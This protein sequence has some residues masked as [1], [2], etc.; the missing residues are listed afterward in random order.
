VR[1]SR[2]VS[3]DEMAASYL[4][5]VGDVRRGFNHLAADVTLDMLGQCDRLVVLDVGAGEG[6]I[7]RRLADLGAHVVAV[8]PTRDLLNAAVTIERDAPR[9]I[10]YYADYVEDLRSVASESVDAAVAVLVLH[11][12]VDLDIALMEL[13]RVLRPRGRLVL[14]IPHP[15]SDHPGAAWQAVEQGSRRVVGD[16]SIERYWSTDE[17]ASVRSVGWHH[18]TVASWLNA[19]TQARFNIVEL[20]EPIG[21]EPRRPDGGGPWAV[22]PRF[23]AVTAQRA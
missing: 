14:V 2:V 20:R 15:W 11:H 1:L 21:N 22:V 8:E 16:Y 13:R 17:E 10:T 19:L 4:M 9:G 12:V 5:M 3:W 7:A 18:R 23:F 6:S